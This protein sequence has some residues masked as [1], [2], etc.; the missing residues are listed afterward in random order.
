[1]DSFVVTIPNAISVAFS[2]SPVGTNVFVNGSAELGTEKRNY[3]IHLGRCSNNPTHW[4]PFMAKS[5]PVYVCNP[6]AKFSCE[7]GDLAGK[8]GQLNSE[9]QEATYLDPTLNF[10]YLVSLRSNLSLVIHEPNSKAKRNC[11]ELD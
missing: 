6:D 11:T 10:D 8:F 3:H 7:L 4:D 9:V 1:M 5:A 2:R